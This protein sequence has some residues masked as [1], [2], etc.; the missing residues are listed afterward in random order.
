MAPLRAHLR[1]RERVRE[2]APGRLGSLSRCGY[3]QYVIL[4]SVFDHAGTTGV[5]AEE[6]AATGT[7]TAKT[8]GHDHAAA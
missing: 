7:C 2:Q 6:G 3:D 4:Q 1:G 8:S 5:M